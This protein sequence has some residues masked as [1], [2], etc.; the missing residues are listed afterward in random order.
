M[1]MTKAL[2]ASVLVAGFAASAAAHEKG[3]Q[4]TLSGSIDTQL[5]FRDQKTAFDNT[6]DSSGVSTGNRLHRWA[7]VND[8]ALAVKAHGHAKGFKYGGMIELNADTSSS[9]YSTL[10]RSVQPAGSSL[11][12]STSLIAR[13]T[14]IYVDSSMGR[15][16]AGST[17]GSYE[18]LRAGTSRIAQGPGGVHG[19]W[20]YWPTTGANFTTGALIL[21]GALPTAMVDNDTVANAAKVTYYTPTY[22]GFKAG[23]TFTPDTEQHGTVAVTKSV[24]KNIAGHTS[25]HGL[26]ESGFKNVFEGGFMYHGKW[27]QMHVK[28]SALGQ[29]GDAK[30]RTA[31]ITRHDLRAWEL[32]ASVHYKGFGVAGSYGDWGKSGLDKVSGT[33]AVAGRKKGDYWTAGASYEHGN[34][35]ASF[36]YLGSNTGGMGQSAAG[37]NYSTGKGKVSAYSFGVDYKLAPGFMPYAEVTAFELKDNSKV[38]SASDATTARKNS[39]TMVLVG[40][41]LSF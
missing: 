21:N 40:T 14:M 10:D 23:L 28:F 32:G 13:K 3:P 17:T 5:G 31:T 29:V 15:L 26:R 39:G 7:L 16:E 8:T 6:L 12:S 25:A 9:K 34:I 37:A 35:G 1:K 24:A 30:D 27:D 38:V 22:A 18:G 33:T 2:L 19:D 41:K 20:K 11:D 4:V 36:T